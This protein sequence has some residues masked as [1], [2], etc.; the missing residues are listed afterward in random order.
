LDR[1]V[2]VNDSTNLIVPV[3]WKTKAQIKEEYG[4]DLDAPQPKCRGRS[5]VEVNNEQVR[6]AI[7]DALIEGKGELYGPTTPDAD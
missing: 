4:L 7:T 5:A 6:K 2:L 1:E 3:V